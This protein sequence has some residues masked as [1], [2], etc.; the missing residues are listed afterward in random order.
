MD[1][2]FFCFRSWHAR[3]FS[4]LA[5]SPNISLRCC[6]NG[7]VLVCGVEIVVSGGRSVYSRKSSE[8]VTW[9]MNRS[10]LSPLLLNITVELPSFPSSSSPVDSHHRFLLGQRIQ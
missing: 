7:L 3:R 10:S 1:F 8:V 4:I 5:G 9:Q 2:S 6:F